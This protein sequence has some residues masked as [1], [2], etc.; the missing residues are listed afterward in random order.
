MSLNARA[1]VKEF[2]RSYR[3]ITYLNTLESSDALIPLNANPA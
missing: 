2:E 3:I 1:Q